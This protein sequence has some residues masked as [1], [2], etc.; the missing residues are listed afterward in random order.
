MEYILD[1]LLNISNCVTTVSAV[2]YRQGLVSNHTQAYDKPKTRN[3]SSV[4]ALFL[5]QHHNAITRKLY[6]T[7]QKFQ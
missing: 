4:N 6:D 2:N 5:L 7:D 1:T 3:V